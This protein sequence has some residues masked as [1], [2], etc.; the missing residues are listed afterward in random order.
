ML[1]LRDRLLAGTYRF[2]P[3]RVF[4]IR[5]PKERT[6]KAAPFTGHWPSS[7]SSTTIAHCRLPELPCLVKA[8]SSTVSTISIG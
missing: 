5:D 1:A 4:T 8:I 2:G 7:S 3:Y 6:I